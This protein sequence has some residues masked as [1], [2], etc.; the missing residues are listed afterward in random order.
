MSV[1]YPDGTVIHRDTHG[2]EAAHDRYLALH[3]EHVVKNQAAAIIAAALP[4]D[5]GK[6][7]FE[8]LGGGSYAFAVPGLDD[9]KR[10][11]I[12]AKLAPLGAASC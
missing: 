10:R 9:A 5:A 4:A 1:R 12:A 7:S 6:P 8:H 3:A 11:E 2:A